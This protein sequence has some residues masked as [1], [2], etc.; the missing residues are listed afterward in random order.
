VIATPTGETVPGFVVSC[1]PELDPSGRKIAFVAA[2]SGLDTAAPAGVF[3][4][5]VRPGT[6]ADGRL[7]SPLGWGR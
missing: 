6:W 5:F 1:T 4:V 7:F 3:N 2:S